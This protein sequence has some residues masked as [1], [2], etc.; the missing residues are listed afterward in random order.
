MVLPVECSGEIIAGSTALGNGGEVV[1]CAVERYV[2]R[3]PE[4]LAL[5]VVGG[6]IRPFSGVFVIFNM[7]YQLTFFIP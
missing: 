1:L 7:K 5:V 4:E 6:Y 3:E 2:V